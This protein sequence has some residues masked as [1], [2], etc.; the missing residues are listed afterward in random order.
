MST[1]TLNSNTAPLAAGWRLRP[2]TAA[3]GKGFERLASGLRINLA[4]DAAAGL[5]VASSLRF[6]AR[7]YALGV[8]NL[9]DGISLFSVAEGAV[10][11]LSGIVTRHQELAEQA[12]NG[13]LSDEQRGALD[14]EALALARSTTGS[15]RR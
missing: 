14:E 9:N 1:V 5:S 2:S 11:E 3:L 15:S 10:R 8:R 7:V 6:D 12:S 13:T 4:G